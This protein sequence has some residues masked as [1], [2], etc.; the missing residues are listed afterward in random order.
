MYIYLFDLNCGHVKNENVVQHDN[1]GFLPCSLAI[2][3]W[4]PLPR[5]KK[6]LKCR[7]QHY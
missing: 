7:V 6:E 4:S 2:F 3:E 5:K 1:G